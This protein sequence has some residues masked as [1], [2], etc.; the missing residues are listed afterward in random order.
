MPLSDFERILEKTLSENDEDGFKEIII[1]RCATDRQLFATFFFPH[2]C[3]LEFNAFHL[4]VFKKVKFRERKVRRVWAAP[5]GSAKSTLETLIYPIHDICYGSE[6]F[7]LFV[8]ATE[9]LAIAK[10]KD[11]RAEILTNNLLQDYFGIGFKTKKVA[12]SSYVAVSALGECYFH[13]AGKGSQVRGIRYKESRPSKIIFD[14]FETTDEVAN[15]ALR[16]KTEATFKEEFGKT[17]NQFTNIV[18]VG[19]VLHKAALLPTLLKNPAYDGELF[20]AVISWAKNKDLWNQWRKIYHNLDNP[21]RREDALAFFKEREAA[22]LEGTEVL[23]PEKESYYD[24]M[25]DLEEIGRRAFFKEKQN[26]PIGTDEPVF[27]RIHWYHEVADGIV[28]ESNG[29]KIPWDRLKHNA[30]GALDPST[31]QVKAKKGRM[32]DY[33][34][35]LTGFKDPKGRL[36]VHE[37]FTKRA[38]PTRYIQ[39]VF[40]LHE[41]WNYQRF[42]V[43]T[44]LYRNL[45]LPNLVDER[46]RREKASGKAIQLPF[47]DVIQTENKHERIFRL[48]PKVNHGYILFNRSLSPEF[49]R[50]LEDFPHHDNDDGPD[51]LEILW[52][53]VN[54]V[55]KAAGVSIDNMAT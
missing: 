43:E 9:P 15:E 24:Q 41:K 14:D 21:E 34:C 30:Q 33:S 29:E 51:C 40:D 22:M 37:D 3:E 25:L 26:D 1:H 48:E 6:K 4:A 52:N 16:N 8:S 54:G 42:A 47:Y 44:N 18:F 45:L 55:Y 12:E 20:R 53:T 7:I 27:E 31:G 5:R 23:W 11:I 38:A 36:L 13:A 46:K 17:G 2:Y 19:T 32:G 35:L 50:M 49:I 10:L 28:I 39:E